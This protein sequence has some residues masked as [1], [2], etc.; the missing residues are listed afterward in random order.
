MGKKIKLSFIVVLSALLILT[1]PAAGDRPAPSDDIELAYLDIY[2]TGTPAFDLVCESYHEFDSQNVRNM[3]PL[4]AGVAVRPDGYYWVML[5]EEDWDAVRH[6]VDELQQVMGEDFPIA[7]S[8]ISPDGRT[9]AD[10]EWSKINDIHRAGSPD[11]D[12]VREFAAE[13]NVRNLKYA[14][15]DSPI[16]VGA[17]P[18]Q[19]GYYWLI[20]REENW[21]AINHTADELQHMMGEDFPIAVTVGRLDLL[22]GDAF[23]GHRCV[24]QY[25]FV[26]SEQSLGFAAIWYDADPPI[27][28]VTSG[29]AASDSDA[30]MYPVNASDSYEYP[31]KPGTD[32]WKAF[33]NHD[34]M[35]EACQ[36]PESTLR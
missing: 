6:V 30:Y 12:L 29:Q 26:G 3:S 7:V 23:G 15:G 28:Q 31:V 19:D 36:I 27:V 4:V 8:V 9:T 18:R 2:Q 25:Y 21:D 34:E 16:I 33:T 13:F 1:A 10:I 22:A 11:Y 24:I 5:K 17:F 14:S 35:L 20:I 32:G